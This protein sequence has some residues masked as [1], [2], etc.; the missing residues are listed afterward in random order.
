MSGFPQ[1]PMNK[2]FGGQLEFRVRLFNMMACAGLVACVIGGSTGMMI[3]A[4]LYNLLLNISIGVLA[5][6]LIWY[7]LT[8]GNYQL[9]Y[10]I[11]IIVI[12]FGMF[13]AFFLTAGGYRSGMPIFFVFAVLFTV[14]M[15]EGR[16][17]VVFALAELLLYTALILYAYNYPENI[18][19]FNTEADMM[20][21]MLVSFLL[22]SLL[23]GTTLL[24]HF[25]LY[26]QQQQELV[27]AQKQAEEYARM[28]S[29]LFAGMSHEMR[30]PL[31]VM[32]AYAQFAVEQIKQ[33]GANEQTLADLSTI[34]DEA[35]RLALMADG[36][37]KVLLSASEIGETDTDGRA[38]APID[39]GDLVERLTHLLKPI[40]ARKGQSLTALVEDNVPVTYGDAGELTQL[41]WNIMQNAITHTKS[42]IESTVNADGDG[43]IIT[44]KD[45]GP[46]IDSD[47][48]PRIFEWGVSGRSGGSGIGLA[49]CRDIAQ[50][51]N[52]DISVQ[53][54]AAGGTCVTI[55]LL[56]KDAPFRSA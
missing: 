7:S 54:N 38:T 27:A 10:V 47:L 19:Q 28:K 11:T 16:K 21:D 17:A 48:L 1:K 44:I 6:F 18:S 22:V 14:F 40:A 12:F 56:G 20:T 26:N 2:L 51:H 37:L 53:N 24:L 39:T 55:T 15:L 5:I 13:P 23:L 35:K 43:V 8:S 25:R 52:G 31:T 9:C 32:S 29:A 3:D 4:G 42:I 36:T 50:K 33:N 34:G 46:G 41:L 49:L 45:D 30:T